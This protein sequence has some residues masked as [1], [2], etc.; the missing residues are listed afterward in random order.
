MSRRS[1]PIFRTLMSAVGLSLA[2]TL[3]AP[4]A[5]AQQKKDIRV[6]M[7]WIIQGT[8][9]PF[10]I[11]QQKGYYK[12]AGLGDV[13]D[14]RRKGRDQCRGIVAGGA[15]DFG[16]VDMPALIKFNA[17]NPNSPLMAV[18]ISFDD[19]P[20][21][22]ITLRRRISASRADLNGVRIAGGPGTAVHD[23][24]RFCSSRPTPAT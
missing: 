13:E 14:R 23:T 20:L 6:M 7:D 21:A 17:Q 15:Y 8:H 5:H 19:C 11:A 10:F 18:Y 2:L 22:F 1:L 4:S 12:E 24:A 3:A 16:W 9:A